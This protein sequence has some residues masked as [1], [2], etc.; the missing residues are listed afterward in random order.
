MQLP[1]LLYLVPVFETV[2][3]PFSRSDVHRLLQVL[4]AAGGDLPVVAVLAGT[5]SSS[6]GLG[7]PAVAGEAD[8]AVQRAGSSKLHVRHVNDVRLA[9]CRGLVKA[10]VTESSLQAAVNS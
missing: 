2:H 1:L 10:H 7:W 8:S 9:L 4:T 5:H 3:M 6:V